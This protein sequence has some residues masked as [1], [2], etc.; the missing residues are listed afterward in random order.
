ML[1]LRFLIQRMTTA[2]KTAKMTAAMRSRLVNIPKIHP[3]QQRL[4]KE[5]RTW[6]KRRRR[7]RAKESDAFDEAKFRRK[8]LGSREKG[9]CRRG[10][11]RAGG[12]PASA[13]QAK[14]LIDSLSTDSWKKIGAAAQAASKKLDEASALPPSALTTTVTM[15]LAPAP[16]AKVS[17][18]ETRSKCPRTRSCALL[19]LLLWRRLVCPSKA[20]AQADGKSKKLR[21]ATVDDLL[22]IGN[23][24]NSRAEASDGPRVECFASR[25][26]MARRNLSSP[27]ARAPRAS[28]R[29]SPRATIR[30]SVGRQSL[31]K[32]KAATALLLAFL[33]RII[34]AWLLHSSREKKSA[35]TLIRR[36]I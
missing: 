36:N 21:K 8:L 7:R 2:K 25:L 30:A 12:T 9:N 31:R 35:R 20:V 24:V 17:S 18:S 1:V 19:S 6:G 33:V 14:K 23:S 28:S 29:L 13:T 34:A 22:G 10:S 32:S 5:R 15:S 27:D 26:S 11:A 3:R 16:D 4:S